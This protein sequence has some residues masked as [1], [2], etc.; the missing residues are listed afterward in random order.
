MKMPSNKTFVQIFFGAATAVVVVIG[1]SLYAATSDALESSE[2][3]AH[4]HE[5]LRTIA[6]TNFEIARAESNHRAF[7]VSGSEYFL[8]ERDQT[9]EHARELGRRLQQLTVDNP[10]QQRRAPQLQ[11]LIDE[12][13][14]I[15]E[16]FA[17][18]RRSEGVEAVAASMVGAGQKV[19]HQLYALTG[20]MARDE[21]ALLDSRRAEAAQRHQRTM[22]ILGG[23]VLFGVLVLIPAYLV[24]ASQSRAR[25]GA[26]RQLLDLTESLPG[27][28][29][30][31]RL[32]PGQNYEFEY[33][34]KGVEALRHVSRD[35]ALKDF[36]VMW[37]SIVDEDKPRIAAAM[38]AATH[39]LGLVP[40]DFR[41][42][43]PGGAPKWLRST[44]MLRRE[45]DGSVLWNGYW[46]DITEQKLLDERLIAAEKRL[47]D[48]TNGIPG[49]VY[50][51]RR[52][53]GG[54]SGDGGDGGEG[55]SEHI[56]FNFLSQGIEP[57]L[58]IDR[59]ELM[60]E[61]KRCFDRILPEYVPGMRASLRISAE[62]LSPWQHEF[63]A[64]HANG[65]IRWLGTSAIPHCETDGST[66]WN[67]YLIDITERKQ[68]ECAL[69]EARESAETASRAKSTFLATMSHE[70][71]TPMS[72]VLGMLELLSLTT[73]N[74]EQRTTVEII[75]GSGQSLLRIIDDILDFSRI[76][77]GKLEVNPGVGSIKE[78]IERV[79]SFYAGNAS[80]K[81]LL[82][83]PF[84][85]PN[86][87]PALW[88]DAVRLQ[89]ILNNLVGNAIKFTSRGEV[90]IRAELAG[91]EGGKDLVRFSVRDT[92]IGISAAAQKQL[93]QPFMQVD[94]AMSGQFGGSGLGLSICSRLAGMMGG[95]IQLDS[96]AGAGTT[97]YFTLPLPIA[98]PNDLVNLK[99]A[100]GSN[101]AVLHS[102]INARR[103][104]PTVAEAI[105]EGTLVLLVDDHPINCMVLL[106][107]FNALGYAA[108]TAENG[109]IA[110]QKWRSGKFS[111]VLTDCN[112]PEMG[113][114]ELARTIRDAESRNGLTRVPII[115]CTANAMSGEA[116]LSFAAGM[117]D[118]LVKPVEMSTLMK[119]LD[120]WLPIAAT[121]EDAVDRIVLAAISHGKATVERELV[122]L[123][124][125]L[126]DEDA[127]M[128][129]KAVAAGDLTATVHAS[130]RISGAGRMIGANRLAEMCERLEAAGRAN[131]LNAVKA[132]LP[133]FQQEVTRVYAFLDSLGTA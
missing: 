30:R 58:G 56:R 107:Q 67:G 45:R 113:G 122:A 44:A 132:G 108:E 55:G 65:E 31:L 70:I 96:T 118:H 47:L 105:E 83:K 43:Q 57:L 54:K 95:G 66:V 74:A 1:W 7:L 5:V 53:D 103:R 90:E 116:Q 82:L 117:D 19:S 69:V 22:F 32:K 81:G 41:V 131:D 98:D 13:L 11:V 50:Q 119:K 79:F 2:R 63:R 86:I 60:R 114:Y 104:A 46:A 15:M 115:A 38:Q 29:F 8:K 40:Y 12:R 35:A 3:I 62:M 16:H 51:F 9:F 52:G 99:L 77:A 33:L 110:L 61:A 111:L 84:A 128:L 27:A 92:G 49:V 28:V 91:R 78:I 68:L 17:Q 94:Q 97:A 42:K 124:R 133:V 100:S 87:S 125:R 24:F 75:R 10:A 39:T 120:H 129:H 76:E 4:T 130:H 85:D 26:E 23:A 18:L 71:R 37:N 112:M 59:E 121:T 123:F 93:F 25:E 88:V 102:T 48:I 36:D 72:G 20:A 14:T 6:S 101:L 106:S 127:E 73:L 80:S 64:A 21:Y 109:V 34:S 126:N 89:Q